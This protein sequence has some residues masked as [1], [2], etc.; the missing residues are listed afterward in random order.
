MKLFTFCC[1]RIVSC[2]EIYQNRFIVE[3]QGREYVIQV[4]NTTTTET[5]IKFIF[6]ISSLFL[7]RPLSILRQPTFGS[8]P[9]LAAIL[10]FFAKIWIVSKCVRLNVKWAEYNKKNS[11]F[12]SPKWHVLHCSIQFRTKSNESLYLFFKRRTKSVLFQFTDSVH[13]RFVTVKWDF[14]LFSSLYINNPSIHP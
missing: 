13:C 3:L 12:F 5:S 4:R 9:F 10:F 2:P 14:F 1:F 6:P 11:F 8:V 7:C